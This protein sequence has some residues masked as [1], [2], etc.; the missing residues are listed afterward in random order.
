VAPPPQA[1][2]ARYL[3]RF[4]CLGPSCEDTCC[5]GWRV[6]VDD[7]CYQILKKELGGSASGLAELEGAIEVDGD[8]RA[9]APPGESARLRLRP[10]GTCSF[11]AADRLCSVQARFGEPALPEVCATYPRAIARSGDRWEVWGSLSCPEVARLCL[12]ADDAM[13]LVDAPPDATSRWVASRTLPAEPPVPYDRYLDDVRA[14]SFTL[15]SA[16]QQPIGTRLF[17][18][19]CLGQESSAFFRKDS[20]V[21]DEARLAATIAHVSA[22][23]TMAAWHAQ[24][25]A[26]PAPRAMTANLLGQLMRTPVE[27]GAFP[28]LLA[29]VVASYRAGGGVI[30]AASGEPAVVAA[31]LWSDYARR[32]ALWHER[33]G[34]RLDL[35]FENYAKNFCLREWYTSSIDLLAHARRLLVRVAVLRLLLFG[36]PALAR[37]EALTDRAAQQ[38]ILDRTAVEVFYKLSRAVDHESTFLDRLAATVVVADQGLQTFAHSTF[39]ALL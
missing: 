25:A 6:P 31:A 5:Q 35:Y 34:A 39:L 36:H 1:I 18:L 11:L 26:M 15:L 9:G 10:D 20:A 24:L 4:R 38:E 29:E 19:A 13:D 37:A 30:T 16:R 7:R 23:A 21:V 32:R 22:P 17:L 8:P 14:A 3:T 12:L 28:P 27:A 33:F 2:T